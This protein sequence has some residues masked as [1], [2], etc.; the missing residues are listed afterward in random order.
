MSPRLVLS[1]VP[2]I[3]NGN[4]T[5]NC[6]RRSNANSHRAPQDDVQNETCTYP[7]GRNTLSVG[8]QRLWSSTV[9]PKYPNQERSH[10]GSRHDGTRTVHHGEACRSSG[11]VKTVI[12]M[13]GV[14]EKPF[15]L[16]C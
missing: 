4:R 2:K 3:R 13:S 5:P 16:S 10:S 8:P 11:G 12:S 7:A 6:G 15:C 1:A 9:R 14:T